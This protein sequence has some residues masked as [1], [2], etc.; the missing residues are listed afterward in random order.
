MKQFSV[1]FALVILSFIAVIVSFGQHFSLTSP[2]V[3]SAKVANISSTIKNAILGDTVIVSSHIESEI[4]RGPRPKVDFYAIPD[5]MLYKKHLIVKFQSHLE[6]LLDAQQFDGLL[7]LQEL[8]RKWKVESIISDYDTITYNPKFKERHRKWGLHLWYQINFKDEVAIKE[9]LKDYSQYHSIFEI[10]EPEII[11]HDFSHNAAVN[12]VMYNDPSFSNQWNYHNSGQTSGTTD[13]DIDLPEAWAIESGKKNVIVAILDSGV[14][15]THTDLKANFWQGAN[16]GRIGYN[17]YSTSTILNSG[18]HGTHVAGTIGAV[19]NNANRVSGVAGGNGD[20]NSGVSLMICQVSNPTGSSFS[21]RAIKRAFIWSADNGAAI[22]QN[23]WGTLPP[24]SYNTEPMEG[25][26]YFIE[27][28]GGS[29]LDK[30]LVVFS[31][32]NSNLNAKIYPAAYERVIAVAATNHNDV[33]SNYSS[34]GSWVDIAAPGG[35]GN[36]TGRILSTVPRSTNKGIGYLIGTSQASPHV[37]GVAALILSKAQGALQSDDIRNILIQQSDDINH[38]NTTYK[39]LLGRG[40]LNA[41][42]ALLKTQE[43]MEQGIINPVDN[44]RI[45]HSGC[46]DVHLSWKNDAAKTV[47]IAMNERSKGLMGI[48]SGDYAVGDSIMTGG[49]KIIYKGNGLSLIHI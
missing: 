21:S 5:S 38:L 23:S 8:N 11:L 48:P 22:A 42:R 35:E 49:G 40:R 43:I 16:G 46:G 30:G 28:G 37:T 10:V 31:A 3:E 41:H 13:A 18:N 9:A 27:N 4:N 44:F 29:V 12:T 1:K 45:N 15:T 47:I 25:I 7:D 24:N 20:P 36:S 26:D 17:F 6:P 32:G 19:N 2:L 34:Y 39:G 14:D 33:R